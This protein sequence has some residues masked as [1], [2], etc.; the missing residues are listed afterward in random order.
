MPITLDARRSFVR[1]ATCLSLWLA[2]RLAASGKQFRHTLTTCTNLYRFTLLWDGQHHPADP[3]PG[4]RDPQWEDLLDKL[5][6]ID[7]AFPPGDAPPEMEAQSLE[8]L[9][10]SMEPRLERDVAAWP[11]P[12]DKPFGFF[13]YRPDDDGWTHGKITLHLNNPF[14]PASPFDD[15]R[16][17]ARELNMLLHHGRQQRPDLHTVS[18]SSWLAGFGPL[19]SL[20]PQE[21]A[22]SASPPWALA[23]H[24]GWWGQFID[25]A[26]GFHE[27][28]GLHLRTTGQFRYP[29]IT[30][31]CPID[32]ALA[33]LRQ[34]FGIETE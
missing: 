2:R 18:L 31:A 32:A 20:F 34:R 22:Q 4:W 24:L 3:P 30:C 13:N 17:R 29:C 23:Y 12:A 14:A 6:A 7:A 1:Q 16:Q 33:H 5:D 26:G 25:R 19:Q 8:L 11:V 27:R 9:W 28:N 15:L 10:P 21:F